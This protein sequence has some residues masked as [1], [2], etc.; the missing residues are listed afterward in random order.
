MTPAGARLSVSCCFPTR[1]LRAEA[2]PACAYHGGRF[3]I[4]PPSYC[5]AP[6]G[7]IPSAP[8][9]REQCIAFEIVSSGV[10][11][12]AAQHHD[13]A[14]RA[15][16]AA[17]ARWACFQASSLGCDA[18]SCRRWWRASPHMESREGWSRGAR[19]SALITHHTADHHVHNGP[20]GAHPRSHLA[21][22]EFACDQPAKSNSTHA[23]P[24]ARAQYEGVP[25]E[26]GALVKT[27]RRA[28]RGSPRWFDCLPFRGSWCRPPQ[29]LSESL[30][31]PKCR[32]RN[33]STRRVQPSGR[34]RA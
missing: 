31:F 27:C 24:S 4:S 5:A 21:G 29:L 1:K 16:P 33:V 13:R 7:R 11:I 10:C 28:L 9:Q 15:R 18:S 23:V 3:L 19:F 25:G 26:L 12:R 17:S 14:A 30:Q 2:P 34:R 8:P 32:T 20:M 6:A 22:C